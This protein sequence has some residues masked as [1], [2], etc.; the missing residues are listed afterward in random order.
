V[1]ND[2]HGHRAGDVVLQTVAKVLR[3][4]SRPKDLVAR[5]GGEEFSVLFS[6]TPRD[7]AE[8]ACERLRQAVA[9]AQC[10]YE[11]G[12]L[13]RVTA[14]FG[15][16]LRRPGESLAELVARADAALYR[17]KEE[18]RNRVSVAV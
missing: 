7:D 13:P 15:L 2:T 8:A 3:D 5:Y 18:G 10:K 1:F 6:D 16:A 11:G 4:G 9:G 12:D 14:S 17:A